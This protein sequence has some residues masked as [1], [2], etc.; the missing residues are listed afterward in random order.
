M[1]SPPRFTGRRH[2]FTTARRSHPRSRGA[3]SARVLALCARPESKGAGKTGWPLH[4]GPSRQKELREGRVTTGTGGY[5]P[6]FPAQWFTAYFVLSP[7]NQ[8]LPPSSARCDGIVANLA[9]AWARQD[10]TTSPSANA[11]HVHRPIRVHRIPHHVRDDA[12]A[13]CVGSGTDEPYIR[14]YFLKNR[15]IFARDD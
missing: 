15:N 2:P 12:Y 7:V 3:M 4:P 11:P 14:F 8:P 9:P 13:P 10:H 5:T 1:S 6:A